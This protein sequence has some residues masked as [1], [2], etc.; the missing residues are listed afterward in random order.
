LLVN[1]QCVPLDQLTERFASA[2][3]FAGGDGHGRAIAQPV[4]AVEVVR[5]QR[6]LQPFDVE[7]RESLRAA[8]SG[9]AVPDAPGINQKSGIPRASAGSTDKFQVER[10]AWAHWLPAELDGLIAGCKPAPGRCPMLGSV[11]ARAN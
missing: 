1:V 11:P 10:F 3:C 5:A 9:P 7:S 6:L 2:L 8:E 4:V